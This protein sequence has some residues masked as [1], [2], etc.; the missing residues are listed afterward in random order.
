ML[1]AKELELK[2]AETFFCYL[3]KY[4]SMR[5]LFE[6]HKDEEELK[7]F[8]IKLAMATELYWH[9]YEHGEISKD[10]QAYLSDVEELEVAYDCCKQSYESATTSAEINDQ[11]TEE[12]SYKE[13]GKLSVDLNYLST[14]LKSQTEEDFI[15]H[16][17][18]LSHSLELIK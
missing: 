3:Q 12:R 1:T 18:E 7:D 11:N 16:S 6:T 5:I 8:S 4:Y 9:C 13:I 10:G 17:L 2:R 15:D 14:L